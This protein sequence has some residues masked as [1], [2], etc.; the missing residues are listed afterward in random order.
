MWRPTGRDVL[1]WLV[2]LLVALAILTVAWLLW[3][4]LQQEQRPEVP[5]AD[6][7]P[8]FFHKENLLR[9]QEEPEEVRYPIS[10]CAAGDDVVS[11]RAMRSRVRSNVRIT[12]AQP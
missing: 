4:A 6:G 12:G 1:P 3:P 7:G 2:P 10:A 9:S 5:S 11:V 8:T